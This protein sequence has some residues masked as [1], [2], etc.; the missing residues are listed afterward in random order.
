MSHAAWNIEKLLSSFDSESSSLWA[1][2][3][4]F[5]AFTSDVDFFAWKLDIPRSYLSNNFA[6]LICLGLSKFVWSTAVIHLGYNMFILFIEML[7]GHRYDAA[8]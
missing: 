3:Q 7:G 1:S 8:L 5:M 2:S 6:I 4:A